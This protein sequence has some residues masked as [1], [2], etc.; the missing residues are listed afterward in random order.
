MSSNKSVI[1]ADGFTYQYAITHPQEEVETL[2]FG[3]TA[4]PTRQESSA[5]YQHKLHTLCLSHP[6]SDWFNLW[7]Y[8]ESPYP[9]S[10]EP[11]E[12]KLFHHQKRL[13]YSEYA[14]DLKAANRQE[15]QLIQQAPRPV[16]SNVWLLN[17][18]GA[19]VTLCEKGTM[20][21]YLPIENLA[22]AFTQM[23]I[24]DA[25]YAHLCPIWGR[26]LDLFPTLAD[27]EV[28]TVLTRIMFYDIQDSEVKRL[29]QALLQG[30]PLAGLRDIV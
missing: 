26:A 18:E 10:V 24:R 11:L 14:E 1:T 21:Q 13:Y 7:A 29:L 6:R 19:L 4:H 8:L 27:L 17:N 28:E 20:G 25:G 3:L 5:V 9:E 22:F 2:H 23:A 30:V 12:Y 16:A 15:Q